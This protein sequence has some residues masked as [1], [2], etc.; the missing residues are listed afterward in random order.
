VL[1]GLVG[2]KIDLVP[3][4][5]GSLWAVYGLSRMALLEAVAGQS[6]SGGATPLLIVRVA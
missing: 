6:G 2:G 3:E 5:D 1:R 4:P